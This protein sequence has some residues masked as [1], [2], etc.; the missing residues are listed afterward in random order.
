MYS[1]CKR[2]SSWVASS[3]FLI[4]LASYSLLS[5][6]FF[7]H[8]ALTCGTLCTCAM[9]AQALKIELKSNLRTN[10]YVYQRLALIRTV[11]DSLSWT[12]SLS[13]VSWEDWLKSSKN[14]QDPNWSIFHL[15]SH[16]SNIIHVTTWRAEPYYSYLS[17]TACMQILDSNV[18]EQHS[19]SSCFFILYAGN[20]LLNSL[21]FVSTV[22]SG[23]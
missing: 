6:L 4:N 5:C 9:Q 18:L 14:H 15:T 23:Y 20:L 19:N 22:Q 2:Q 12:Y 1:L 10:V 17:D 3:S 13:P 16:D 21:T 11:I 7:F 8:L